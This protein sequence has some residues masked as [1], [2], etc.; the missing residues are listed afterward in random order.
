MKM[1]L[2]VF[3]VL[4]G[5]I[6]AIG[7]STT[8]AEEPIVIVQWGGQYFDISK[9]IG[10][11]FTKETGIPIVW[12]LHTGPSAVILAKIQTQWPS[13]KYDLVSAWD[14]VFL[15]MFREGWT[16]PLR[17][18]ELPVLKDISDVAKIRDPKT[19]EI[20]AVGMSASFAGWAYRS[21]KLEEPLTSVKQLFSPKLKNRV[22]LSNVMGNTG[23]QLVTLSM[24]RGGDEFDIEPGFEVVKELA[25][26]G[27]IR[28]I[29]STDADFLTTTLRGDCWAT[30]SNM[31]AFA[32][33]SKD[34]PVRGALKMKDTKTFLYHEGFVVLKSP[35][36][37]NAKKFLNFFLSADNNARYNEAVGQ[38]P[39]NLKAKAAVPES[40]ALLTN[41]DIAQFGY[42]PDYEHIIKN[43]DAWNKKW[44]A[45]VVPVLR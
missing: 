8:R 10:D 45:E 12:E 23:L 20:H 43:L 31:S 28:A 6:V 19:N 40:F 34:V 7:T 3:A 14:P 21:D 30:F 42:S 27:N 4:L 16:V 39:T 25:K 17:P 1:G 32:V 41:R 5:T 35:R 13:V 33:A 11:Q 15:A 38:V 22:C 37:A 36:S 24:F 26:T 2:A 9:S 29:L 18:E 44:E